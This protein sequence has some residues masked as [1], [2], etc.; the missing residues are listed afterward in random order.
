MIK[1]LDLKS[2]NKKYQKHFEIAYKRVID[3]GWYLLGKE[4]ETFEQNFA[5]YC[6]AKHCISLASGLDALSLT[7]QALEITTNDEVIVPSHTFI[8]TILAVSSVGAKPVFVEPD[9]ENFL[10]DTNRIEEKIT[11]KTKAI[12]P[13][14]LYGRACPIEPVL[15]IA[16]KYNL[17]VLD[18]AAQA[19]GAVRFNKQNTPLDVNRSLAFSFYPGK[20]LGALADAG[21][22]VTND[23]KLAHKLRAI[24]NYGSG[25]KYYCKYTGTNSRMDELQAAF[26]DIKLKG[27]EEDNAKRR[28]IAV[29]YLKNIKNE[30]IIL[31]TTPQNPE[32]HVWHLFVIR[33]P[34]RDKLQKNLKAKG[35]QTLI[36]YPVPP[37][38]Q[39]CCIE[40]NNLPLPIAEKLADEVLSL[41]ISPAMTI[42]Q[43]KK[44]TKALNNWK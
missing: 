44:V 34:H 10:I 11:P 8:A 41:P 33:A 32:D 38:K 20:N 17:K 7:L 19:H 3:S 39:Q 13:V 35:I 24:R 18:D 5:Q 28:E 14:H 4:T 22:V 2:V 43:A 15:S 9:P 31:P 1:F 12:I 25:K 30:N 26:L 40:Y 36:H 23:D 27:L 16:R 29:Y 21:A 37:H 6:N 42:E